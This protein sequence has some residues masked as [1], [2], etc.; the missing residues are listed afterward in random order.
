V[1]VAANTVRNQR[2]HQNSHSTNPQ[3]ENVEIKMLDP[4]P[5]KVKSCLGGLT[6]A[7]QVILRGY[8]GTLRAQLNDKESE[9]RAL[10]DED[11]NAHYHGE[12]KCTEDQYVTETSLCLPCCVI[13]ARFDFDFC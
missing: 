1:T 3:H 13:D 2:L 6:P 8:I 11:P 4:I 10:T 9:S 12:H 7:Q 5:D